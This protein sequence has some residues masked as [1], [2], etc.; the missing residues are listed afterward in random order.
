MEPH[1]PETVGEEPVR[2]NLVLIGFMGTGKSAIGR[3]LCRLLGGRHI[4]TDYEIEQLCGKRIPRI[5]QEDGEDAFRAAERRIVS[6]VRGI[7]ERNR[8]GRRPVVV[9]TGGGTPLRSES[10]AQLRAIGRMILLT[11]ASEVILKRV[12]RS[13]EQRPLLTDHGADPAARIRELLADRMPRYAAL[14]DLVVDTTT[15]ASP[16]DAARHIISQLGWNEEP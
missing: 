6:R 12:I 14:A 3:A 8:D 5:F 13:I 4:D 15:F 16:D 9:S 7:C 1:T 11:A 2:D 10:A